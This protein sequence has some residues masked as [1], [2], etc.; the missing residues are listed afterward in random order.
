MILN[1]KTDR[2]ILSELKSWVGKER[3]AVSHVLHY[4]REVEERRLYLQEAS[5]L[6][7]FCMK[8]LKYSRH[9]AQ[10]R[11]DAM[12]LLQIVPE[13][14]ADLDHGRLSLTVA[15]QAMSCFR[16][17]DLRREAA[18]EK[19]LSEEEHK[20]VLADLMSASTREAD[21]KLATHFPDQPQSEKA[22]PVSATSTR[23]EF[24]ADQAAMNKFERLMAYHFHKT[25]G[26][27]AKF[28]E[29]LADHE[30]EKLDMPSR[31]APGS[32]QTAT[33][34]EQTLPASVQTSAHPE[35][36]A[37][38]SKQSSCDDMVSRRSSHTRYVKKN[39]QRLVWNNWERGCDHIF[40][41]GERCGSRRNLQI[42]HI[43]D[44][45]E[46]GA[47][48]QEN[49]RLLCAAHNRY[50]SDR[51]ESLRRQCMNDIEAFQ[52]QC[53]NALLH[54]ALQSNGAIVS[55]NCQSQA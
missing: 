39:V 22:K 3:E 25:G 53:L 51:L 48:T 40:S 23:I 35:Q 52:N 38:S 50:R 14:D 6:K 46:G 33:A 27:W 55:L 37:L 26:S 36:S 7:D 4:L 16:K 12:R 11:I 19:A 29:I 13:L 31:R 45:S 34:R 9:E 1:N 20:V 10:A 30:I 42:D 15:A 41:N 17:E 49:L 8:V 28:F 21:R 2:Q 5:S 44:F 32:E 18:G 24:N 54:Q 43:V 47:N